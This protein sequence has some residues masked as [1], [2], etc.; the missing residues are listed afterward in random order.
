[1]RLKIKW[2][3]G[4]AYVHGT[5]PSGKRIRRALKTQ[6]SSRAEEARAALESRI[7]RT[8]L[9]GV[10]DGMTFDECALQ[11]AQNGGETRYLVRITE[12]LSG[13]KLD[14]ITPKMVRDAAKR[15]YPNTK[16]STINRCGIV[17]AAAVI[18]FGHDQGWCSMIK[19]KGLDVAAVPR[20]AVGR[21]YLD[22]LRPHIPPRVFAVM[23]FIHQ[24]GRR[25]QEALDLRPANIK[26]GVATIGK[27]KNGDKAIVHMT[28]EVQQLV[29]EFPPRHGRVFGYKDRTSLYP[30]LRRGCKKAGLPYMGTHQVGRH[31]FATNL[32]AAGFTVKEIAEAGGWKTTRMV[33]EIY[34]HPVDAQA[35]ATNFFDKAYGKK[36]A[37]RVKSKA[38]KAHKNK[39]E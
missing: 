15:A 38:A 21:D 27:T 28:K 39:D 25:V 30:T 9:Y 3:E 10:D 24:S 11:Y 19:V 13:R 37:K 23:L 26:D 7:W 4:W 31:S 12:Q 20:Q 35:K 29:A 14:T 8:G 36:L 34:E 22:K 33:S 18:N 32:T 6:D 17:P 2:I 1:M 5:D 16:N